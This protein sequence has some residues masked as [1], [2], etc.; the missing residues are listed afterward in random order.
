MIAPEVPGLSPYHY[1]ANNPA[2]FI[3]LN[4]DSINV[5]NL[6][7]NNPAA[8]H[9][10]DND[11]QEITGLTLTTNAS[12][13]MEY[14]KERVFLGIKR[15]KVDRRSKRS[16]VARRFLKRAIKSSKTVTVLNDP[17][18]QNHVPSNNRSEIHFDGREIPFLKLATS[19]SLN[20]QT[21]GAGMVFLHV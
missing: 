18:G 4:G 5:K 3:D 10:L 20:P 17:G 14:E 12:G 2:L 15:A 19:L 1:A 16:A 11:L 21:V 13:N 8:L 9:T 7:D 6:Q